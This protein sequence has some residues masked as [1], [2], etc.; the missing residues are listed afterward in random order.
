M[1][2]E[3]G[4]VVP[5]AAAP[6]RTRDTGRG[7]ALGVIGLALLAFGAFWPTTLSL[8]DRWEDTVGRTYTHG[9]VVVVIALWLIWRER[10]RL[11]AVPAQPDV[12]QSFA[13]CN[14]S[15]AQSKTRAQSSRQH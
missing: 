13:S 3:A 9:Y 8:M 4:R 6:V 14:H 1:S 15:I 11:A 2:E 7:R 5:A 12:T 10:H